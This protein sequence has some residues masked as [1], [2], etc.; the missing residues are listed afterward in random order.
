MNQEASRLIRFNLYDYQLVRYSA[1]PS[2]MH[3]G[4][5]E[6]IKLKGQT[7][8]AALASEEGFF[9]AHLTFSGLAQMCK[10]IRR[11]HRSEIPDFFFGQDRGLSRRF[12]AGGTLLVRN[13]V[14][15]ALTFSFIG[16]EWFVRPV[17]LSIRNT[18]DYY[19]LVKK[20]SA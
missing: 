15:Y 8:E 9:S 14:K 10:E 5:V 11:I 17:V 3:L 18:P 19:F 2:K 13:G 12:I 1:T 7:L 6:V 16:H 4:L 20:R